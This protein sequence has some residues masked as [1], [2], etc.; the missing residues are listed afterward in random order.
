VQHSDID[1][2]VSNM[3]LLGRCRGHYIVFFDCTESLYKQWFS[4]DYNR[5]SQDRLII[6]EMHVAVIQMSPRHSS[7]H[8][9]T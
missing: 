1:I 6:M 9:I 8:Y 4:G 3:V 2:L 5:S 7:S